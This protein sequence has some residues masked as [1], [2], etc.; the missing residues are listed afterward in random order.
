MAQHEEAPLRRLLRHRGVEELRPRGV[1]GQHR[2]EVALEHER[3][4]LLA[5]QRARELDDARHPIARVREVLAE[6][7]ADD[8]LPPPRARV[9]PRV[10]EAGQALQ[11]DL[12][13]EERL[14]LLV[15][16]E[17]R[18]PRLARLL[19]LAAEP[20]RVAEQLRVRV[21]GRRGP[22]SGASPGSFVIGGGYLRALKSN[23]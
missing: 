23:G 11:E 10:R 13:L 8:R 7:E 9:V 20:A 6:V 18:E 5:E 1:L 4:V 19:L 17:P 22:R 15:G 14:V 3:P 2:L 16:R 21:A 12:Q